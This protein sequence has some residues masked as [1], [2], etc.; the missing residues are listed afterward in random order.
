MY[1]YIYIYMYM[2]VHICT[3]ICTYIYT[4][5]YTHIYI[6]IHL[7]TY[8][9]IHLYTFIFIYIYIYICI[10]IHIY[11]YVY[12]TT[13][14]YIYIYIQTL[15]TYTYIYIYIPIHVHNVVYALYVWIN[16]QCVISCVCIYRRACVYR[17]MHTWI[18]I[19]TEWTFSLVTILASPNSWI[20]AAEEWI[21][22]L[23]EVRLWYG[24]S[25][26]H[27]YLEATSNFMQPMD[28]LIPVPEICQHIS[29]VRGGSGWR[30]AKFHQQII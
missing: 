17:H 3:Y 9:Y 8:I 5:I 13:H 12:K 29:K 21:G 6:C 22:V 19:R 1:I 14:Q 27:G 23:I 26:L 30:G 2:Y 20:F 11:T 24:W 7:H 28:C 25:W 10:H 16:T 4:Y 15:Y 18:C